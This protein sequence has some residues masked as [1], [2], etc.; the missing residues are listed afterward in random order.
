MDKPDSGAVVVELS[1]D[2]MA[3][4]PLWPQ[5]DSTY[6]L[7]PE[8]LMARL[9]AWQKDF[10]DNFHWEDGWSSDAAKA[11][12]AEIAIELEAELR[13]A[14]AEKAELIVRLWPLE[15]SADG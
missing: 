1:P 2:Y 8:P 9:I 12:W 14:L 13:K 5:S 10:D 3:P 15:D 7:V 11:R 6:A 4:S